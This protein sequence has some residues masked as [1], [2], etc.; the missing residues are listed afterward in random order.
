MDAREAIKQ[1][2]DAEAKDYTDIAVMGLRQAPAFGDAMF[3]DT[4]SSFTLAAATPLD[5]KSTSHLVSPA[6]RKD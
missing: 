5:Q 6:W 4:L 2:Y 3:F 1:K